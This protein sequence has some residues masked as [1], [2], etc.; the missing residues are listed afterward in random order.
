MK[1]QLKTNNT[2]A[3]FCITV[4]RLSLLVQKTENVSALL[5]MLSDDPAGVCSRIKKELNKILPGT[6][7]KVKEVAFV[8]MDSDNIS[9]RLAF[10][11]MKFSAKGGNLG[12][13][14]E[15]SGFIGSELETHD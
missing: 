4:R 10:F 6:V 2:E 11:R 9:H 5:T 14:M 12:G 7:V 13:L 3:E 1:T 8:N 15:R